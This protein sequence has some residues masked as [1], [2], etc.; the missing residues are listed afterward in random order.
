MRCRY[1]LIEHIEQLRAR[2]HPA[3]MLDQDR[4]QAELGRRQRDRSRTDAYQVGGLVDLQIADLE[5]ARLVLRS[6]RRRPA[7]D[8]PD[9]QQHLARRERLD[10]VVVGTELH[11][12]DP[13]R[14]LA[15]RRQQDGRRPRRR[16]RREQVESVAVGQVEVEHQQIERGLRDRFARLAEI[17]R[18]LDLETFAVEHD[19][20]QGDDVR[21]VVDDQ[22]PVTHRILTV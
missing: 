22:Y 18:G 10:D 14:L 3:G 4:E 2:E 13:V 17:A 12:D 11:P 15:A 9:P 1:A 20:E 5:P 8:R 19:A 6:A 21:V 7:Q 16:Q